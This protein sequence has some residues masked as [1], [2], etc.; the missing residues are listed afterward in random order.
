M[1]LH[2]DKSNIYV[3]HSQPC[4][5]PLRKIDTARA[6]FNL[7]REKLRS[8]IKKSEDVVYLQTFTDVVSV[9]IPLD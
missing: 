9:D 4:C 5:N 6:Q 3:C 7:A 1:Q 2:T 8:C